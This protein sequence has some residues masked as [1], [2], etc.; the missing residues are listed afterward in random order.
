MEE[1]IQRGKG[2]N[3]SNNVKIF[4]VVLQSVL[5]YQYQN[6]SV[7]QFTG[8]MEKKALRRTLA[9]SLADV[10]LNIICLTIFWAKSTEEGKLPI[11]ACRFTYCLKSY[12]INFLKHFN[13]FIDPTTTTTSSP[14]TTTD[15]GNI[16]SK[17]YLDL[18]IS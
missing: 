16:F 2:T 17:N 4:L 5:V 10:I 14:T 11:I 3:I 6:Y 1:P 7:K 13:I 18:F 12:G 9:I 15:S 8:G